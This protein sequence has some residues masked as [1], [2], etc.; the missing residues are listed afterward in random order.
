MLRYVFIVHVMY[1]L[2]R[3]KY[4]HNYI[5]LTAHNLYTQLGHFINV[6][7]FVALIS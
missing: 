2:S 3:A 5:F 1:M 7:F 6:F 4:T